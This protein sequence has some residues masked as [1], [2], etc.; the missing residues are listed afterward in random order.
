[1][2]F[3]F[4]PNP[5]SHCPIHPV[6]LYEIT[7]VIECRTTGLPRSRGLRCGRSSSNWW[8]ALGSGPVPWPT[9]PSEVGR[10]HRVLRSI[11]FGLLEGASSI[12]DA[13]LFERIQSSGSSFCRCLVFVLL[14]LSKQT[15]RESGETSPGVL[16]S[17]P[18]FLSPQPLPE[19]PLQRLEM[20]A[21]A[22]DSMF[23]NCR[24]SWQAPQSSATIFTSEIIQQQCFAAKNNDL[25]WWSFLKMRYC[26]DL[27]MDLVMNFQL[28]RAAYIRYFTCCIFHYMLGYVYILYSTDFFEFSRSRIPQ[29]SSLWSQENQLLSWPKCTYR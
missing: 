25:L 10:D 16:Q 3:S 15:D 19:K 12:S 11:W 18:G 27:T 17:R 1:M 5:L 28:Q 26:L 14:M 21:L 2:W 13:Y 8:V 29:T 24:K 20:C 6:W 23:Q 9:F 7:G 22:N 4:S